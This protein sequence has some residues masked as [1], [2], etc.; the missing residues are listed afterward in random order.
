MLRSSPQKNSKDLI[1]KLTVKYFCLTL[2]LGLI[3]KKVLVHG[4][5]MQENSQ[6]KTDIFYIYSGYEVQN[7]FSHK[8]V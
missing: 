5:K 8:N 1:V 3:I 4:I 6:T 2:L 7:T